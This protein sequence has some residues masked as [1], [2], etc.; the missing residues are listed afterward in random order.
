[1]RA[2]AGLAE[3]IRQFGHGGGFERAE[4]DVRVVVVTGDVLLVAGGVL[5]I[6][7]WLTVG[8]AGVGRFVTLA[9][10]GA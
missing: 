7:V 9:G 8:G 1:M 4:R 10:V 6:H 5:R 3:R 2:G